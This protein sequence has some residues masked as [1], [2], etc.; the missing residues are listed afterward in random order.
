[1]SAAKKAKSQKKKSKQVASEAAAVRE[2]QPAERIR[3][4]ITLT[5]DFGEGYYAGATKGAILDVCPQACIVDITHQITSHDVLEA[6]FSLLCSYPYYP[7]HT[8][9]LVV[10][11]PGV[12]SERRGLIV[13]AGQQIFV[14]PDNGVFSL[15]YNREQVDKVICIDSSRHFRAQVSST[16]H[17]RDVF[18]PVAAWLARGNPM[19]SFGEETEDYVGGTVL[20]VQKIGENLLEGMVIHVDKFGNVITSFSPA[21]ISDL[22]GR[23]GTPKFFVKGKEISRQYEFYAEAEPG[24]VFSLVG[25]SGYYELAAHREPASAI[26]DVNRGERI[27]LELP[28]P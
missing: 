15:V 20:P 25:S 5:T 13:S 9:H 24:E 18:G 10:V 21:D 4:I 3:P 11:D 26:L 14:G 19:E 8:V 16:F 1:M 2:A 27:E 17:G 6:S 22:L 12:G 23:T 7:P 28:Q